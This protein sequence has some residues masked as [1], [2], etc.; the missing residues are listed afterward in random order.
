MASKCNLLRGLTPNGTF[1][2]FSEYASNL[3][4]A[5]V[6][7]NQYR[8]SPSKFA[9]LNLN[10]TG[11]TNK[12]VGEIF[13]NYYE[14]AC[15]VFRKSDSNILTMNNLANEL[16]WK[17]LHKYGFITVAR[18][19]NNFY[20]KEL[21]YIGSIDFIFNPT[22]EGV[23]YDELYCHIANQTKR[24][25]Y[26]STYPTNQ[27]AQVSYTGEQRWEDYISGY[28][29]TT[30]PTANADLEGTITVGT[31][32]YIDEDDLYRMDDY[33][34]K[35]IIPYYLTREAEEVTNRIDSDEK[36]YNINTIIVFFDIVDTNNNII[37]SNIPMG[38][39]FTGQV[40]G[41]TLAN[42]IT[43][44]VSDEDIY[45]QGTSYGLRINTK[46][47]CT[48][49]TTGVNVLNVSGLTPTGVDKYNQ[50]LSSIAESQKIMEQMVVEQ[51]IFDQDMK[52]HLALFANYKANVPYIRVINNQKHW[53][54]NGKDLG[55]VD[56]GD[57]SSKL[58]SI[59]SNNNVEIL[60]YT[61]ETNW[62]KYIDISKSVVVSG[63]RFVVD[64]NEVSVS[65]PSLNTTVLNI[66]PKTGTTSVYG[67]N[68]YDQSSKSYKEIIS[69]INSKVRHDENTKVKFIID[70]EGTLTINTEDWTTI[71][72]IKNGTDSM[73]YDY[74]STGD[75]ITI[76][77]Y[78]SATELGE[79][80]IPPILLNYEYVENGDQSYYT[81]ASYTTLWKPKTISTQDLLK[82][83]LGVDTV[84]NLILQGYVE[85]L[86]YIYTPLYIYTSDPNLFYSFNNLN[87]RVFGDYF[88]E[89]SDK[90]VDTKFNIPAT[91]DISFP[92]LS[93]ETY[94]TLPVFEAVRSVKGIYM[95]K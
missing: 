72:Y 10:L 34:E 64:V 80:H 37:Y 43:K 14:N 67:L 61:G 58:M 79:I 87:K 4:K 5:Y 44:V 13:Q 27:S 88:I 1:Y 63:D 11:K 6:Q 95:Q 9:A 12:S 73:Y 82:T 35:A 46:F 56:S 31:T 15:T 3:T 83:Q 25:K 55:L 21:N 77:K 33:A 92:E 54:V 30:Y 19:D 17:T 68:V 49:Q 7:E 18:Q 74:L 24:I 62:L 59:D 45:Q 86:Y 89:D 66:N 52:E 90:Y 65:N 36:E 20:I 94:S 2:M 47:V 53:F 8:V 41:S 50:V 60:N 39:Y 16:L 75:K 28:D 69:Y 51:E 40:S 70:G 26:Y 84:S 23:E 22:V 29:S 91:M 32:K 57:V 42:E 71:N 81:F 85:D 38:I 78:H 76:V 93:V 48:P